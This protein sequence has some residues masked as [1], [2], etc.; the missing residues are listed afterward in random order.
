M[1]EEMKQIWNRM[2]RFRPLPEPFSEYSLHG[3][4]SALEGSGCGPDKVQC[5]ARTRA[6]CLSD[7]FVCDGITDC[8]NG[9][10]E[11]PDICSEEPVKVG[12]TYSG[13]SFW[14]TCLS[15]RPHRSMIV[16]THS[17]RHAA[18]KSRV[19]L[20]ATLIHNVGDDILT[21]YMTGYFN[22]ARRQIELMPVQATGQNQFGIQCLFNRGDHIHLD[23]KIVRPASFSKCGFLTMA[24]I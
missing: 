1:I 7:L 22:F 17:R 19:H 2:L 24:R 21:Q 9:R 11:D 8:I 14:Q 15:R 13:F 12:R 10:D 18:F 20:N 23:C 16:L 5:G 3:R 4:V 6:Q